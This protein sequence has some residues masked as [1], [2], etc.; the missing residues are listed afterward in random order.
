MDDDFYVVE[1]LKKYID[2]MLFDEHIVA[3]LDKGNYRVEIQVMGEKRIYY[4]DTL[5]KYAHRYPEELIEIL[6]S[7]KVAENQD[8]DIMN[9]NW[10][11]IMCY[12]KNSNGEYELIKYDTIDINLSVTSKSELK[13]YLED[14]LDTLI[15]EELSK[16][17]SKEN[18]NI[19]EEEASERE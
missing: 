14:E 18:Q 4:K 11:E 9:N 8:V 5:Y 13:K 6:K 19:E 2:S 17:N 16:A 12:K 1:D 15:K 7:G 3:C 10:Y